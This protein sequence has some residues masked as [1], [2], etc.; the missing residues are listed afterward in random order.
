VLPENKEGDSGVN[1]N[2]SLDIEEDCFEIFRE[3]AGRIG[4][5]GNCAKDMVIFYSKVKLLYLS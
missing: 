5:F 3:N 1:S 4:L 2:Y